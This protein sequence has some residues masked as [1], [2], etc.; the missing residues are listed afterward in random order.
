MAS[1]L[2][3]FLK[4]QLARLAGGYKLDVPDCPVKLNQNENPYDWPEHLKQLVFER[5]RS[6]SW[7]RYPPFV[8]HDFVS[9]V[10]A[11]LGAAPEQTLVGNGSNELLYAAFVAT[12][13]PGRKVVIP[14]PTFTVY[15]LLADLLGAEVDTRGLND[16]LQ[17]EPALLAEAAKDAAVVVIASPNNPT[18]GVLAPAEI[19]RLASTSQALWAIDEAY[20]EFHGETALPLVAKLPNV[21]VLRTF[22]KALATA[23]LRFGAMVAHPSVAPYFSAAKLPYNLNLFTMAAV[24]VA[25]EHATELGGRVD[26]LRLER[27]RVALA[28][29]AFPG[30]KVYPSRANFLLFETPANPRQ[31]WQAMV[32]R[33]VLARDVSSYPRLGRALRV[34]IGRPAENDAFLKALNGSLAQTGLK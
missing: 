30:V 29:A 5:A 21:V 31:L 1:T 14:Q 13:G 17:Y 20:F 27:E 16:E 10:A 28:M 18:G 23:G 19:E 32:G 8:P 34:S 6:G 26:E 9:K 4:P 33:G 7:N 15:K 22:S 11:Y 24:E 3:T 12:L 2:P 25:M